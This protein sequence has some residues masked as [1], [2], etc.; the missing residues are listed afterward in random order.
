MAVALDPT[1]TPSPLAFL[2]DEELAPLEV[3]HVVIDPNS[4]LLSRADERAPIDFGF[5]FAN[6]A[7]EAEARQGQGDVVL[8][9]ATTIGRLPY[10]IEDRQRRAE[11]NR[12][13]LALGA[14]GLKWHIDKDQAIR[15]GTRIHVTPPATAPRLVVA[16]VEH[17]L[18]MKGYF[19]L[20]AELAKPRKPTPG[21]KATSTAIAKIG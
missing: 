13:L 2:A 8:D 4:G 10:T 14:A 6:H 18:P 15:V 11:L 3:G 12:T 20:L 1:K 7:F 19:E 16:L 21:R 5:S 17:L 9:C